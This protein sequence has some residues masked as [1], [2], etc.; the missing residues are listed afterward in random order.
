MCIV[1][2]TGSV[3]E[4]AWKE[5]G[6]TDMDEMIQRIE[7]VVLDAHCSRWEGQLAVHYV[8]LLFLFMCKFGGGG[9]LGVPS[10]FFG[11]VKPST[12]KI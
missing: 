1:Q 8:V 11:I 2:L 4:D 12:V 7:N 5:K 3:L 6:K 9:G 10:C